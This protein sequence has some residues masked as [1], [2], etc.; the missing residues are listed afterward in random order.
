M[1]LKKSS[2]TNHKKSL[3][4][5]P[6]G[7]SIL[8]FIGALLSGLGYLIAQFLVPSLAGL[9]SQTIA[10]TLLLIFTGAFLFAA[11]DP[12]MRYRMVYG[13]R[14]FYYRFAGKTIVQNPIQKLE[15]Q[16]GLYARKLKVL[17]QQIGGIRGQMNSLNQQMISNKRKMDKLVDLVKEAQKKNDQKVITIK[18]RQ[19][20]RLQNSNQ[21]YQNLY[22]KMD[23]IYL[24]LRKMYQSSEHLME[25]INE[26]VVI[27]KAEFE[28][29][30]ASHQAIQSS[31]DVVSKD[32]K[33]K[34]LFN[35][36][37]DQIN[38]EVEGHMSQLDWFMNHSEEFL[39]T[40]DIQTGIYEE[41][42]L[43]YLDEF[44]KKQKKESALNLNTETLDLNNNQEKPFVQRDNYD[45]FLEDNNT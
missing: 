31:M 15:T 37:I 43:A 22:A 19:I 25:D 34:A 42:G 1:S 14:K 28:A 35:Q 44:E 10:V 4:G 21:K 20:A 26:I 45:D 11:F 40:I 41:K 5:H 13:W 39:N 16:Q 30:Q 8:I 18:S 33:K 38:K 29:V 3:L 27:K 24:Q 7:V 2:N 9:F 6:E 36:S 32:G 23:M 12:K 17:G